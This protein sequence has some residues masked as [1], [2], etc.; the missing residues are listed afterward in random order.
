MSS[1]QKAKFREMTPRQKTVYVLK[2]VV[3]IL[4]FG[5][6]FPNHD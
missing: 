2:I 6:I 3:S 4:S 1:E 5:M